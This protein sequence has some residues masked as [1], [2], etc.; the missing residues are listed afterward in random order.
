EFNLVKKGK[1]IELLNTKGDRKATGSYYTPEYLVDYI[2]EETLHSLVEGKTPEG[3]LKLK[4]LDPSMGSGHFLLGVVK[5]FENRIVE[6]QDTD[7][8]VKGAVDF[9]KV[10]KEIIKHCVFGVDINSLATQL[11]KFSLWIY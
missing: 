3:I 7:K 10:R 5:Y 2:V 6:L 9:D 4:V 1:K 11:A 8:K